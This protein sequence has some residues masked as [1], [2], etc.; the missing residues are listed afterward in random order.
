MARA[1]QA[2]KVAKEEERER[3]KKEREEERAKVAKEREEARLARRSVTPA[4]AAAAREAASELAHAP[5][6]HMCKTCTCVDSG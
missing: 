4:M 1:S 5:L 6:L 3:V 2:A